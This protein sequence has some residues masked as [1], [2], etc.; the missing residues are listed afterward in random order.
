MAVSRDVTAKALALDRSYAMAIVGRLRPNGGCLDWTG[1]LNSRGYPV[2]RLDGRLLLAHRAA[3]ALV[4]GEEIPPGKLVLHDCDRP[5][6]CAPWHLR[7]A[8][9]QD[10]SH[11]AILRGRQRRGTEVPGARLTP[12]QV[13][14]GRAMASVG[15]PHSIIAR[16]FGVA[17]ETIT[18]AVNGRTWAWIAP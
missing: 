1:A 8:T 14:A 12:V 15:V 6:C 13:R 7:I 18:N 10:N 9:H 5:I 2:V 17:R 3:L 11:D 4:T 16:G